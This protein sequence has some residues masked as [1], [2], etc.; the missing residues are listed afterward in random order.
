MLEKNEDSKMLMKTINILQPNMDLSHCN[1][2]H[3]TQSVGHRID[4][5]KIYNNI[6]LDNDI[7][8]MRKSITECKGKCRH[9]NSL[10]MFY[11]CLYVYLPNPHGSQLLAARVYTN[12]IIYGPT[13]TVHSIRD[14]LIKL[15][16][17][18]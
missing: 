14:M 4:L 7:V 18:E 2:E 1:I 6:V 17:K 9:Y 8:G 16:A 12:G 3:V 10:G 13:K 5:N 15:G 11:K